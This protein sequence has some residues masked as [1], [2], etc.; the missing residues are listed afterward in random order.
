MYSTFAIDSVIP[1]I[2]WVDLNAQLLTLNQETHPEI[3]TSKDYNISIFRLTEKWLISIC[4]V[5]LLTIELFDASPVCSSMYVGTCK[6]RMS[7][8]CLNYLTLW[9]EPLRVLNSSYHVIC[10]PKLPCANLPISCIIPVVIII[11]LP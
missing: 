2:V 7:L 3:S 5:Y 4:A 9:Y 6:T 1:L 11:S 8:Y 10:R